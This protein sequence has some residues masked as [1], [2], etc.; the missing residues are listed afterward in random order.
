MAFNPF[1][2]GAN[3]ATTIAAVRNGQFQIHG[4]TKLTTVSLQADGPLLQ[5]P[6]GALRMAVG[7]EY[8]REALGGL[9]ESGSTT[10][11]VVVPSS[12]SRHMY[13]GFAEL[14]VPL[15]GASNAMPGLRAWICRSR[16][17]TRITAIS[18]TPPIPS[19]A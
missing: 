7:A 2:V 5:L 4:D 13:A 12:I 15:F 3:N 10:A 18:A 14:F 6:G 9:L 19:W 1:G 11:P 8:R 16:V 17:A